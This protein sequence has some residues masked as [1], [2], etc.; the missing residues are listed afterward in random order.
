MK[1]SKR[2]FALICAIVLIGMYI[3]TLIFAF[4]DRSAS[5]G[6]LKASIAATIVL[7]VMLYAYTLL[8]RLI[9]KQDTEDTDPK[10]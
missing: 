10:E 1:K 9:K 8:Y 7:P 3:S 6:L 4:I 2:I 5:L